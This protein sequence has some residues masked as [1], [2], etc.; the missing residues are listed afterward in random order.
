MSTLTKEHITDTV[1]KVTTEI[2][3]DIGELLVRNMKEYNNK[4]NDSDVPGAKEYSFYISVMNT[5]I[6]ASVTIME[7]TLCQLLAEDDSNLPK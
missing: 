5:A 3:K 6:Q 1:N 2:Q 7:Q 4:A